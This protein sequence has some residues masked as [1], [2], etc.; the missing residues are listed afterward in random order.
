MPVKVSD[1]A[2]RATSIGDALKTVRESLIP[3]VSQAELGRRAG[4]TQ[5][6]VSRYEAGMFEPSVSTIYDLESA[7]ETAHGSVLREAGMIEDGA[8]AVHMIR[9]D[10]ALTEEM[11]TVVLE[12]YSIA[13]MQSKK[14]RGN[15]VPRQRRTRTAS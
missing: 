3:R 11:R 10:P 4:I 13:V 6:M 9:I 1:G 2:R 8:S 7:M 12:T 15:P 14:I 5:Q